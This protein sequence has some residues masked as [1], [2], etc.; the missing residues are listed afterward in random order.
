MPRSHLGI[1]DGDRTSRRSATT[2][3]IPSIRLECS[4]LMP[5]PCFHRAILLRSTPNAAAM[6]ESLLKTERATR[7][8]YFLIAAKCA[9]L[10]RLSAF[11]KTGLSAAL[12]ISL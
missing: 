6:A 8:L 4:E 2:V 3:S 5:A 12:D 9:G 11:G 1:V 7:N 10:A